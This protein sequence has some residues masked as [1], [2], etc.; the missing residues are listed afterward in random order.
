MR[1][2]ENLIQ[3]RVTKAEREIIENNAKKLNMQIAPYIRMVAQNPTIINFDYSVIEEHTK[4]VGQVVNSVNQ[5]IFTIEVNN[6]FQP[7]EIWGIRDYVEEIWDTENKLLRTVR[8]QWQK[9]Y[10]EI[11]KNNKKEKI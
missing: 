4:Q 2:R 6:D 11:R 10:K 9:A 5:L 7:K 8:R 3:V 1:T